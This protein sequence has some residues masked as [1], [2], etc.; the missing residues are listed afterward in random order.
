[1]T[2]FEPW[3]NSEQQEPIFEVSGPD[4]ASIRCR[5]CG[6]VNEVFQDETPSMAG[7][8]QDSYARCTRCGSVETSDPVFGWRAK[9]EPRQQPAS[10]QADMDAPAAVSGQR[11]GTR[12]PAKAPCGTCPYR[13]DVPSGVWDASEYA[14]LPAYDAPTAL[15]P[16]GL[17][18]CHQADGRVCAGWAGCH[19]T[20][21]LLALRLAALH[22]MDPDEVTATRDYVSPVPLFGSGTEAA[23]H[24][25]AGIDDPDPK[26]RRAIHRLHPKI[27]AR[28]LP[29]VV[30]EL[31]APPAPA[32]G[33]CL[34]WAPATAERL[35]QLGYPAQVLDVAGWADEQAGVVAFI[36]RTVLLAEPG[37]DPT[38]WQIVDV[39]AR[40]FDPTLPARWLTS[41]HDYLTALA[42]ATGAQRVTR[43]PQ[44]ST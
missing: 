41:W 37:G 38:G 15:Q 4:G 26:A 12:G 28:R 42:E 24:G 5:I 10:T 16:G 9:P 1:M 39:T 33:D 27:S 8:G 3:R 29:A 32:D 19:D 14:K 36:H 6:A 22:G 21:N 35:R 31:P 20:D 17:F 13:R 40:Q 30:R 2:R 25:M 7:Y 11:D 34:T 18:L 43:W 44:Q 23:E